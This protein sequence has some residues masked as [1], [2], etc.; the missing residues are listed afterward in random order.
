MHVEPFVGGSNPLN[1][2]E[3]SSILN[4]NHRYKIYQKYKCT[5]YIIK[6]NDDKYINFYISIILKILWIK[7]WYIF[8]NQLNEN[9][10]FNYKIVIINLLFK[11]LF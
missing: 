4:V 6:L 11:V 3:K 9:F 5:Q 2:S 1:N 7:L 10:N 8:T